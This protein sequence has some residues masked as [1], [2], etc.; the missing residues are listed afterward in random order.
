MLDMKTSCPEC[1]K[2]IDLS[3]YQKDPLKVCPHCSVPVEFEKNPKAERATKAFFTLLVAVLIAGIIGF[4]VV[5][6]KALAIMAFV[7]IILIMMMKSQ[8][9]TEL[10][11]VRS[12]E[13][14]AQDK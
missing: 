2:D 10:K 6:A 12:R 11:L 1:H 13:Q 3:N 5:G 7:Q 8:L 9:S 4:I 14:Q